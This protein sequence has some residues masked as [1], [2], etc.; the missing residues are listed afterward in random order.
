MTELIKRGHVY[1]AQPPLFRIKKGKFEQY[2][3]DERQYVDVMIKR[4]SDGMILT[5][6]PALEGKPGAKLEGEALTR[7]MAQLNDYLN[8]FDKVG[9]RLRN[10]DVLRDFIELFAHEGAA[11]AKKEDFQTPAKLEEMKTRLEAIRREHQFR[12]VGEPV[13]DAEHQTWSITFS[14]AQGAERKIDWAL[15]KRG[16]SRASYLAKYAQIKAQLQAPFLISYASK[17]P[18]EVTQAALDEADEIQQEEGVNETICPPRQ[19]PPPRPSR[20]GAVTVPARTRSRRRR[21]VKSSTTSS[22]KVRKEYQVQRYKG[23]GEMTAPQ[24]WETTMDPERRTLMQVKLEDIAATEE[25]FTTLMGEDVESRRKF[26]ERRT[27]ST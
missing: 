5:Y 14:D 18:A 2:I 13:F 26:I 1:I 15:A 4:A 11:P 22:S 19:E 27:L 23:L 21:R 16:P 12:G 6:G 9:K 8:F 3:K 25:I 10:E 24:L 17:T 20:P 7:Y